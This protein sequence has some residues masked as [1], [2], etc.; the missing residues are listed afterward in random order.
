MVV[1]RGCSAGQYGRNMV[2]EMFIKDS[3]I[4]IKFMGIVEEAFFC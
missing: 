1:D 3:S 4:L 2:Y